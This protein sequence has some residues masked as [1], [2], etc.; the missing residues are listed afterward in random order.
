MQQQK[1]QL[2]DNYDLKNKWGIWEIY[3]NRD[4]SKSYE[5]NNCLITEFQ[6]LKK[7]SIIWN[8]TDLSNPTKHFTDVQGQIQLVEINKELK[9][10]EG[11]AIFKDGISPTWEDKSNQEGGDFFILKKIQNP[12]ETQQFNIFWQEFTYH[13]IAQEEILLQYLNMEITQLEVKSH[14]TKKNY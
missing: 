8:N 12:D 4:K 13:M 14:S 1:Q 6:D 3:K 7:F 2:H 5:Q 9:Q 11:Y 10:I